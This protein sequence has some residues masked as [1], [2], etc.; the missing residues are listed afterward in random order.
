MKKVMSISLLIL[1]SFFLFVINSKANSAEP[2]MVWIL[3]P[4]TYEHVEGVLIVDDV[5]IP[6]YIRQNKMETYIRFYYSSIPEF[7]QQKEIDG[8][9]AIFIIT[10][11]HKQYSVKSDIRGNGYNDLYTF[12]LETMTL[13]EGTTLQRN[14]SLISLRLFSTLILEGLVFFLMGYRKRRT[15]ILFLLVNLITQG[16]LNIL[17]NSQGPENFYM[18]FALIVYEMLIIFVE[19]IV[20]LV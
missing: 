2:P 3:V 17:I 19:E 7:D 5:V 10:L 18:I 6:G 15:W 13:S 12:D 20:L 14:A 1:F 4:G 11:D 16:F 9:D 8:S